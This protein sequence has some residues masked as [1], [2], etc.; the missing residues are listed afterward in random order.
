MSHLTNA[1]ISVEAARNVLERGGRTKEA[2]TLRGLEILTPAGAGEAFDALRSIKPRTTDD[3]AV[4]QWAMSVCRQATRVLNILDLMGE[5]DFVATRDD[6]EHGKPD[7][8]IYN[9]ALSELQVA[10]EDSLAIED[11]P[12]GVRAA[13]SAGVNVIAVAT[14]FTQ[15]A[16]HAMNLLPEER[17][18][19]VPEE[20]P[21]ILNDFMQSQKH[22]EY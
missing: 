14:P 1:V 3:R 11:S 17:I 19:D 21:R 4:L 8:E 15:E 20:L 6:V 5:F 12:S 22:G 10:P 16:L 2:H 7:P 18:V 13:L 9:L